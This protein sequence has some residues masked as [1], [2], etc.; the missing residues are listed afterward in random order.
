MTDLNTRID[1]STSLYLQAAQAINS[2]GEI[3]GAA[4][5]QN[6]GDTPA[7]LAIPI[8]DKTRSGIT[9][10]AAPVAVTAPKVVLPASV[11]EQLRRRRGFGTFGVG[12]TRPQ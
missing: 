7:F 3:V 4:F 10:S 9:A 2:S 6:T 8:R 5:D 12:L 1:P 11:S